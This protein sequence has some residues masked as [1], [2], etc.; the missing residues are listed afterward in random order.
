M[1][2]RQLLKPFPAI[3]C[4]I[5][6]LLVAA[7][8]VVLMVSDIVLPEFPAATR[9]R[10]SRFGNLCSPPSCFLV[11][12]T[13]CWGIPADEFPLGLKHFA[14]WPAISAH[15]SIVFDGGGVLVVFALVLVCKILLIVC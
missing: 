10:R 1:L 12:F 11:P 7:V 14:T 9:V 2:V 15:P 5:D 3:F 8:V 13:G 4:I 6:S